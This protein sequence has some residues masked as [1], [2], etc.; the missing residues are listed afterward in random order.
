[1]ITSL[2]IKPQN[3]HQNKNLQKFSTEKKILGYQKAGCF[4]EAQVEASTRVEARGHPLLGSIVHLFKEHLFSLLGQ[5]TNWAKLAG[6]FVHLSLPLQL[7]GYKCV[8]ACLASLHV[9]GIKLM[10]LCLYGK[11]FTPTEQWPQAPPS[12]QSLNFLF[13]LIPS[14]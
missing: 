9:L 7:W 1:M 14:H 10:S 11:C 4:V 2:E 12:F 8:P 5:F 3:K 6:Q 13:S